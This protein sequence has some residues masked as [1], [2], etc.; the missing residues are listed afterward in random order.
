MQNKVEVEATGRFTSVTHYCS[1]FKGECSG[2]LASKKN[3]L[4][5]WLNVVKY[6]SD[7]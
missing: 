2:P 4:S 1:E 7:M 3:L 6:W 5:E